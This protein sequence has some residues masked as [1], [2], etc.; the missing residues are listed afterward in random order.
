MAKPTHRD[1]CTRELRTMRTL[2]IAA[3][4]V[5]SVSVALLLLALI[6][7]RYIGPLWGLGALVIACGLGFARA[8]R[9]FRLQ[10]LAGDRFFASIDETLEKEGRTER[11]EGAESIIE[12]V[13]E[14]P[15]DWVD[16]LALRAGRLR[17]FVEMHAPE[18]LIEDERRLVREAIAKVDP[19]VALSIL[20]V[21]GAPADE[22]DPS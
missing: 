14:E 2:G 15:V 13:R 10:T 18:R 3:T 21:V 20:G 12:V 7:R 22:L 11:R 16:R 5:G 1:E 17:R 19:A 9:R 4:V 8:K 6:E